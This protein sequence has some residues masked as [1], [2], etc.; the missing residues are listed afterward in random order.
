MV[1]RCRCGHTLAEICPPTC[2]FR[3]D[4]QDGASWACRALF[5]SFMV[6][7]SAA[8]AK[9]LGTVLKKYLHAYRVDPGG[10]GGSHVER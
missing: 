7:P 2:L 3:R 5:D 6:A 4:P 8:T 1:T 9:N 10:D